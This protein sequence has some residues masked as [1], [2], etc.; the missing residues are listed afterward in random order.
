MV[1]A[2]KDVETTKITKEQNPKMKRKFCWVDAPENSKAF[3]RYKFFSKML[4]SDNAPIKGKIDATPIISR[5]AITKISAINEAVWTFSLG[6]KSS[7]IAWV[8]LK[9]LGR[10][11]KKRGRKHI[12]NLKAFKIY[13]NDKSL[14][15]RMAKVAINF[16]YV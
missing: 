4:G 14:T 7:N 12:D 5:I 6:V 8:N 15:V 9:G 11:S 16:S 1:K 3:L 2:L 13:C 10:L